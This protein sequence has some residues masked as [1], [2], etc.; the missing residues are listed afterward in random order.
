MTRRRSQEVYSR[1]RIGKFSRISAGRR[2]LIRSFPA[3]TCYSQTS[4]SSFHNSFSR[5]PVDDDTRPGTPIRS[6]VDVERWKEIIF[7][8]CNFFNERVR[9]RRRR[10][11]RRQYIEWKLAHE[12]QAESHRNTSEASSGYIFHSWGWRWTRVSTSGAT[13]DSERGYDPFSVAASQIYQYLYRSP[14]S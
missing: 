8:L 7:K 11:G 6:V 13:A 1:G 14:T 3:H 10:R 9:T 4:A 5:R 2:I 12:V